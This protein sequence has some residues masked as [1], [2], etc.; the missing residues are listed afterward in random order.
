M[1]KVDKCTSSNIAEPPCITMGLYADTTA[2]DFSND[3]QCLMVFNNQSVYCLTYNVHHV[4]S[5]PYVCT[6]LIHYI[7]LQPIY[8]FCSL[9]LI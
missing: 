4:L 5:L 3:F 1:K 2:P 6:L 9:V 7:L 8:I